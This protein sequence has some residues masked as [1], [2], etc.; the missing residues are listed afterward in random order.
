MSKSNTVHISH[1][2]LLIH[3]FYSDVS[4]SK[5]LKKQNKFKKIKI[6]TLKMSTGTSITFVLSFHKPKCLLTTFF[7]PDKK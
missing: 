2:F 6:V 5:Y 7:I 3:P 1:N 4:F